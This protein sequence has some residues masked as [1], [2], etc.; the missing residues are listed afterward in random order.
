MSSTPAATP[1]VERPAAA[2]APHN[3]VVRGAGRLVA[4]AVLALGAVAGLVP[5]LWMAVAATHSSA[6]LFRS[7]PP[8]LP[9]GRLLDNLARLQD[10]IG[11]G[12]VLLNSLG[13]A[14]VQTALSSLVSAMCG[15]ALAKHRFRGRGLV[16]AAVLATMMIP[17]QVLLVPLFQM[18]ASVGW[19]DSYQAVILPFLANS[20]GILLMRQGFVGFPDELIESARIDGCGELRIFYRV[21]LPCVRPQLGA[22]VIFT[23]MAAWNSFIWP[24][25]ML[26]S[27]DKYTVPV[28][29]N[30]LTGLSRVDYSG[31]MLGSLLATLP[32][33]ALFLLFQRQ[34][35]A[36]LLGGAVKE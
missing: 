28:A 8:F 29:L 26:N 36:G 5:F 19:I 25:L 15:Y 17:F 31:L 18:M 11:F 9:G 33:L 16:L 1:D 3:A 22:L 10:T 13:I 32:L 6:D 35:V 27:E 24:L 14:V 23:F 30:T 20:F 21:V 4:R 12:R 2:G 7:P 34:F